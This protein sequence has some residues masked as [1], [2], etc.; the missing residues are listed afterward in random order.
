MSWNSW[1]LLHLHNTNNKI[2]IIVFLCQFFFSDSL[3]KCK[4]ILYSLIMA[5]T[6]GSW[7]PN[8]FF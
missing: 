6:K 8:M 2:A 1:T 5:Y 3:E 7:T 4:E